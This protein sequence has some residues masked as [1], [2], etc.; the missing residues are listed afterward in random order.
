VSGLHR[1]L[2]DVP[3]YRARLELHGLR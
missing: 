3:A 2:A 1:T